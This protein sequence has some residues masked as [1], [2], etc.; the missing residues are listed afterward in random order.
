MIRLIRNGNRRNAQQNKA[1]VGDNHCV[2]SMNAKNG[3]SYI[4]GIMGSRGLTTSC[5]YM[6]KQVIELL[7]KTML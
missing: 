5:M 2:T 4:V 3:G 7:E 1:A 6:L